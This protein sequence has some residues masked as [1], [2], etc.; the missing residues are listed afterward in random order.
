[1]KTNFQSCSHL[2]LK[3][4]R[5]GKENCSG[6]CV[7]LSPPLLAHSTANL[8]IIVSDA[9][10]AVANFLMCMTVDRSI[11]L[12]WVHLVIFIMNCPS[13]MKLVSVCDY[14]QLNL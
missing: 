11:V 7:A 9:I 1:M 2:L 13:V 10:T 5:S 8:V 6:D 12:G 3:M 14:F 4:L